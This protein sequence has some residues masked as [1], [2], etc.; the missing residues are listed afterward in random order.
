MRFFLAKTEPGTYS[1]DDLERDRRTTWDGVTNPQAV[2]T[3]RSMQPGDRVFLYHSGGVS[4]VVGLA[5]AVSGASGGWGWESGS[6][7]TIRKTQSGG[8]SSSG[9]GVG[10]GRRSRWG[11]SSSP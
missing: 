5:V 11:R 1:I 6:R 7:G 9:T 10:S 3:I 2:K 4:A 8:W